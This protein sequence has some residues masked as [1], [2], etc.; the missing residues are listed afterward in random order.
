MDIDEY[1]SNDK[2]T[3]KNVNNSIEEKVKTF[4]EEIKNENKEITK[5]D[6]IEKV[7]IEFTEY[8]KEYEKDKKSGISKNKI[9]NILKTCVN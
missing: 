8:I 6:L 1:L 2:K 4:A 7:N 5:K 9:K 3:T